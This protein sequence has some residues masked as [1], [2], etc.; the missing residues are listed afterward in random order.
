MSLAT[1]LEQIDNLQAPGNSPPGLVSTVNMAKLAIRVQVLQFASG[2]PS[3]QPDLLEICR[4]T[5]R[6]HLPIAW[7]PFPASS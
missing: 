4:Q 5:H 6:Q 2:E 7:V 3:G 1:D